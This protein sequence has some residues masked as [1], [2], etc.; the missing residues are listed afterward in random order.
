MVH[1]SQESVAPLTTAA[2]RRRWLILAVMSVGTLLVFLD[3]TV[4][5][6]ALPKISTDLGAST[7]DLQWVVDAYVVVLAGTLL[8]FGSLGDRYGRRRIM[9]IGL[10][11]FGAGAVL[12]ALATSVDMLIGA[13]VVQ[14]LGAAMVL[15]A[16]LSIL[17]AVF[18]RAERGVAIA[19]WTAV[20]GIG[21]GIGP[22][23]GGWLVDQ[24]NWGAAFWL[25]VPLVVAGLVGMLIVPESKDE[26]GIGLDIP[27]ALLG[28]A[29][30]SALVFG[31]IRGGEVGWGTTSAVTAL[32]G[33]AVLLIVFVI[34][35]LRVAAPMLPLRFFRE[36]DFTGAVLLIGI[37][38]FAM[39]V[40][41][42][43]LTQL[44]Q[45]VQG[46]SALGAGTVI[47]AAPIGLIIGSGFSGRLMHTVGPR[48]LATL[49]TLLVIAG[50]IG[51]TQI[52]AATTGP[53]FAVAL[54]VFGVGAGLGLPVMTD[55]VMAAVPERD[56]G[57]GSAVNDVSRQLGGALG[58][59]VIGSVVNHAYRSN[60]AQRAPARTP[61]VTL[62]IATE[63]IG[64]AHHAAGALPPTQAHA[65]LAATSSAFVDAITTGF[66]V[67][68]SVM[69]LALVVALVTMPRHMRSTQAATEPL[70]RGATEKGARPRRAPDS[71][72]E[73]SSSRPQVQDVRQRSVSTMYIVV[74]RLA[75]GTKVPE[76][77]EGH[78][79]W[80]QQG[81]DDEVFFLTGGIREA[82]GGA[83]LAAGLTL[84]ELAARLAEDPFVVHGVVVTPEV[85][86]LEVTINDPRLA[87]LAS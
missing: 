77:L 18:P 79:Q 31:L 75:D 71:L 26:R 65:L 72:P 74:L 48:R 62:R 33:A 57:V 51:L 40:T 87:V 69:G 5:N 50:L 83:I 4:V 47:V 52:S 16:T 42:F 13:R 82:G 38:L 34:V 55:T 45:I 17:T 35:E 28:T 10:V 67:S 1:F 19:V 63:S 8:L 12:A 37:V 9:S 54:V 58:V 14:G 24:G 64:L 25:F 21:A 23:V 44:L 53:E 68:T 84:D 3:D 27:G 56:A 85:L 81:F 73:P 29:G 2:Y 80:L 20:G 32:V 41:F 78:R 36:R 59:A 15:P 86:D 76:H 43:F 30:L 66:W 7:S 49:M 11:T 70:D 6:T 60:L 39:F 46:R 22:V 61:A